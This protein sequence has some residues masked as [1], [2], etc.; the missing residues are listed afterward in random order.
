[1]RVHLFPY[2]TLFR[3]SWCSLST[4]EPP[5]R[6]RRAGAAN[7]ADQ[8]VYRLATRGLESPPSYDA[9]LILNQAYFDHA[10]AHGLQNITISRLSRS[11]EHTSELQSREN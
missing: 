8:T 1:P 9:T 7:R 4:P 5:D 6:R 10:P 2:T 3:S 11:E